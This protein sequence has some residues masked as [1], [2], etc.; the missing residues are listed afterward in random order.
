MI[1]HSPL[2]MCIFTVFTKTFESCKNRKLEFEVTYLIDE[3]T[4]AEA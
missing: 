2:R 1:H 4:K 3:E